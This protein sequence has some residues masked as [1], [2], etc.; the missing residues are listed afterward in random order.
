VRE[1]GTASA[2]EWASVKVS[3]SVMA[4]AKAWVLAKG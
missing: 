1:S 3:E 2:K 4:W